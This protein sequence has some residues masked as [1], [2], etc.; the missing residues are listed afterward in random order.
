MP[1]LQAALE[2]IAETPAKTMEESLQELRNTI[3]GVSAR[4][5]RVAGDPKLLTAARAVLA[6]VPCLAAD[7]AARRPG[8]GAQAAQRR[9][10]DSIANSNARTEP[11]SQH[12]SRLIGDACTA[13]VVMQRA[14][15]N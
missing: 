5:L 3:S 14:C 9:T 1:G 6:R 13:V 2:R 4:S 12:K 8:E 7:G 11:C 10:G 15:R